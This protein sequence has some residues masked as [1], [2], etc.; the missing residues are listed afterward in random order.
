MD[1]RT[2]RYL[3]AIAEQ[4]SL[5]RAAEVLF[6]GQ[7]SLSRSMRSLERDLGATLFDRSGSPLT[8][9]P[10]G[11]RAE[12]LARQVLAELDRARHRVTAVASLATGRLYVSTTSVLAVDL[13][14]RVAGRIRTLH[15]GLQ[16]HVNDGR[17]PA[18]VLEDVRRG[19][20]E[21]GLAEPMRDTDSV[22]VDLLCRGSLVCVAGSALAAEIEDPVPASSI[23]SLPL[24]ME[25]RER[26]SFAALDGVLAAATESA[27][28]QCAHQQGVWELVRLGAGATFV[29]P[30]IALRE[31]SDLVIRPVDP[32]LEYSVG[33][34]VRQ[35]PLSPA[36]AAFL[37]ISRA[38]VAS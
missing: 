11:R 20:A 15:P 21:V 26:L 36:A 19:V 8:L 13:L 38:V 31:L 34:I 27:V 16:L 5:T 4:G 3:V 32:P 9:T 22:V 2:A 29:P 14:A 33:T 18:G 30:G 12:A 10:A 24:V 28:I 35:G 6:V 17:S 1:L 23:G 25:T 37:R 7:P